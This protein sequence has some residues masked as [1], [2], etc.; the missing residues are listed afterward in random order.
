MFVVDDDPEMR[1]AVGRSLSKRGFHVE[2]F[3]SAEEFLESPGPGKPGC[4]V[5]DFGLPGMNG[6][7][8]QEHLIK[9]GI[10]TPIIF[11]TGHGGIPESV[12]ATKAGAIDFLEKPYEPRVLANRV[13]TALEID[14][15]EMKARKLRSALDQSLNDL[16]ERE[17][18]IFDLMIE[19]PE[20]SSSKGVALELGIS[21][22]TVDKHRAQILLK[23][24][25]RTLAELVGR[26]AAA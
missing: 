18:E 1:V 24:G 17:R 12:R 6:L 15:L 10:G 20:L 19:R 25:C 14:R 9:A 23:T 26:Y 4:I 16:T 21:P 3:A 8:L 11:I 7:D 5:L 13:E 22:R 2:E